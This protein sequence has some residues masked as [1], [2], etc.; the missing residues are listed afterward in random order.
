MSRAARSGLTTALLFLDL[1]EFKAVNDS[2]GHEV[3]DEVL[4]QVAGRMTGCL[5]ETDLAARLG[6][7]EFVVV[8]ED[9]AG[10][11]EAEV[12]A[13]RIIDAISR[14]IEVGAL[15]IVVGAAIG[16]ALARD[17][18]EE[19]LRL[20][21]R[22]DAAM[23]R[24]KHNDRSAVEVFDA[25]L[26]LQV[27]AREDVENALS[28][29]VRHPDG[30][31]L[32]LVFQPVVDASTGAIAGAEALLR[33]D[34][35]GHGRL[36]P[37]EF[38][39]IAEATA[40]IID[41]DCWVLHAA[42]RQLVA[43]SSIP[44]LADVP[45]SVNISGRHLLAGLLPRHIAAVLDDS[46]IDPRRLSIEITE[47]VMLADIA[48]AATELAAVRALGVT[49]AIDDFGTGYTSLAYLQQ[50]PIDTIK[51]DRSFIGRLG[52][53]RGAS[54]VRLVTDVG[55]AHDL[56]IVAE[57][58]ETAAELCALQHMGADQLQGFLFSR[59][60]EPDDLAAWAQRHHPGHASLLPVELSTV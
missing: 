4:R 1:N 5:R 36:A 6:G 42:A 47:T 55:H 60:L 9:L 25:A 19:P 50:L 24:A 18:V 35:P 28:F 32:H 22:A 21:G 44:A 31:G 52:D 41:V 7:D 43:W 23:Y 45:L 54:L 56:R 11:A 38:I 49:V 59:P 57:G 14:P 40:L 13:A 33:W 34:R 3:G 48:A 8:A 17:G 53:E 15:H 58:V 46:G 12:L 20:L 2:H 27:T 30:G 26:Q 51:I 39:P 29:A 10:V 37:D 16:V